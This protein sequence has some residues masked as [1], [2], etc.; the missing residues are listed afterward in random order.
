MQILGSSAH[1][2]NGVLY[3]FGGVTRIVGAPPC[4]LEAPCGFYLSHTILT[5]AVTTAHTQ[6]ATKQL[7]MKDYMLMY[8]VA[9]N[10]WTTFTPEDGITPGGRAVPGVRGEFWV[11]I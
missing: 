4:P 2:V 7:G 9:E 5:H 3:V 11:G 8:S 1:F 6:V 10:K